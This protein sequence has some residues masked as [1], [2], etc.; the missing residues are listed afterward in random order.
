MYLVG[1]LDGNSVTNTVSV[2]TEPSGVAAAP[3][4]WPA[5]FP[6]FA[7]IDPDSPSEEVVMVTGGSGGT[8][9]IT[10]GGSLGA[11]AYGTATK[12]HQS[13][14]QIQH[15]A[16]AA[17]FDEANAHVNSSTQVHGLAASSAVVGTTDTQTLTNKT[18]ASPTITGTLTADFLTAW[19]TYTPTWRGNAGVQP[20]LNAGTLS[21]RYKQIGKTVEFT[22]RWVGGA[23]TVFGDATTSAYYFTLPVTSKAGPGGVGDWNARAMLQDT[24]TGT[25]HLGFTG[26]QNSTE[27]FLRNY[28]GATVTP[29]APW[30]WA[31]SDVILISGTYEAA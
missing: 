17:D 13:G 2:S 27:F 9:N 5:T 29:V 25:R 22:M 12:T 14:A 31:V 30:T 4:G 15:V 18:L 10:R 24:S 1:T 28:I 7:V 16:T 19:N 23:D 21:G 8:L 3:P 20:V 26:L 6:Y 11:T